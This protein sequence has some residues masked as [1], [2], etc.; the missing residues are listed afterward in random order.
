MIAAIDMQTLI[1]HELLSLQQSN[2][3]VTGNI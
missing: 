2:A 1:G 3:F